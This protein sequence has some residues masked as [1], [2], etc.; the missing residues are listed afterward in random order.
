MALS[1]A[2]APPVR[3]GKRAFA[4]PAGKRWLNLYV[5][6][7]GTWNTGAQDWLNFSKTLE[8]GGYNL[9]VH[10]TRVGGMVLL[11]GNAG[12]PASYGEPEVYLRITYADGRWDYLSAP[13]T[14]SIDLENVQRVEL[15][16]LFRVSDGRSSQVKYRAL[17][18]AHCVYELNG[19]I[20]TLLFDNA[21][22]A[23][24]IE[25]ED[26]RGFQ[27]FPQ[28]SQ[29]RKNELRAAVQTLRD[30]GSPATLLDPP[31][32]QRIL[33][34]GDFPTTILR[35][36][37]AWPLY[38][39][40]VA[41]SLFLEIERKVAWSLVDYSLPQLRF[42]LSSKWMLEWSAAD[43]GYSLLRT[44]IGAAAAGWPDRGW[45]L[46]APPGL[47]YQFL[48]TNGIVV[49]DRLE[50]TAN[51]VEWCRQNMV[52]F[53]GAMNALDAEQ[54]WQ[55]RGLPPVS[56]I[57]AGTPNTADPSSGIRHRTGGCHGTNG[58]LTAVLRVVNIPVLYLR[59][60]GTGHATPQFVAD[61]R[62][63]SHG[64]DPYNGM[65]RGTPPPYPASELLIDQAQFDAW[66]GT[67]VP[68]A[69]RANNIG[70]RTYEL[71]L[72]H[73]TNY[74]LRT[75]C[76]DMAAGL[77]HATGNVAQFFNRWYTVSDL[78]AMNL[79]TRMDTRIA[80]LGGCGSIPP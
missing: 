25:W 65:A 11:N 29:S 48:T 27:S 37:D 10:E 63:L 12:A 31:P 36:T 61:G 52:H 33:A 23:S 45:A 72:I 64:D 5:D 26:A 6:T 75:H 19:A 53:T 47:V 58:F 24:A 28:W 51:V 2:I 16:I 8:V 80:A 9:R 77:T 50:T 42:L 35:P 4:A 57:I 17:V 15:N 46:P 71:A 76:Q 56:R 13:L 7:T 68:A 67:A 43:G 66:F 34:D 44:R 62:Y 73:L 32:N 49:P 70:R 59:P 30:G 3:Y 39:A 40:H 79:W 55:Y 69:T 1:A 21:A 18:N 78:E 22:I 74:L 41:Q 20:D 38:L 14:T 60:E 54:Q